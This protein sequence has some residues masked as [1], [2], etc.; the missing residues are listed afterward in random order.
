MVAKLF[1]YVA[2]ACMLVQLPGCK[3]EENRNL[4][5]SNSKITFGYEDT[6]TT[7]TISDV[8][9]SGFT[10]SVSTAS[11]LLE[12]S[13]TNGTCSKNK[14]DAFDIRLL[15]EKVHQDSIPATVTITA[16]T[17]EKTSISLLILGF[18]EK[19]IRYNAQILAAAYDQVNNRLVL[20][21]SSNSSRILDLFDVGTETFS[22]IP[23][24]GS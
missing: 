18:P 24:A 3:K 16:S 13:K 14:P 20:L 9:S 17:G 12:F 6:S 5:V 10:W 11:D 22:H 2:L 7:I 19:K 15:R 8:G 21:S 4:L 1:V 23:L